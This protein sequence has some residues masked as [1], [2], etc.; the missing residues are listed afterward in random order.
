MPSPRSHSQKRTKC[1]AEKPVC[2]VCNRLNQPCVYLRRGQ[3]SAHYDDKVTKQSPSNAE[4]PL[5]SLEY[6]IEIY[7]QKLYFQPLPLFDIAILRSKFQLFPRYL[8]WVF[9][10]LTLKFSNHYFYDTKEPQ[11]I[12]FYTTSCRNI[13]MEQASDGVKKLEILQSLCLLA[14]CE[15]QEG[16][17]TR[18][19]M[20]IG[21][22]A[23]LQSVY[24]LEAQANSSNDN[25]W[26]KSLS[27]RCY[28]SILTLEKA[29][30]V[31]FVLLEQSLYPPECPQ[32]PPRPHPLPPSVGRRRRYPDLFDSN[33]VSSDDDGINSCCLQTIS[34]WGDILSYFEGI[35]LGKAENP[36]LSSSTHN[37]LTMKVYELETKMSYKHLFR[38]VSFQDRHPSDL[39]NY[40]EY[41]TPWLL[42]QIASHGAQAALNNPFIHLVAL[43]G[44]KGLSQ[45]RSFLQ[46]T[47]DQSLYHSGWV[48]RLLQTCEDL[49]FTISDPLLGHII[50]ATATIPWLFQFAR[51][52]SVSQRAREN[53]SKCQ[54]ALSN[55]SKY[56]PHIAVK[57]QIL[58]NLQSIIDREGP[59]I[60]GSTIQFPPEMMWQVLI[61]QYNPVTA[62]SQDADETIMASLTPNAALKITTQ[63][64]QPVADEISD[65][66]SAT[67]VPYNI[68]R[69]PRDE[70][71]DLDLDNTL[72]E[73]MF[74]NYSWLPF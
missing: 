49:S 53:L 35:R 70:Y 19:N 65:Q 6:F 31:N 27:S 33:E 10:A 23:R 12:E 13:V 16:K 29:F 17:H 7:H 22:A 44:A 41:W 20:T 71:N 4:P 25:S 39:S 74:S 43:R 55:I 9:L 42:M 3:R 15:I 40:R 67:D 66:P 54:L 1:P 5:E 8:R 38:N 64:V 21:L 18:A 37:Q 30:S 24:M 28:W 50:A 46:Q 26:D 52:P 51:D 72:S 62:L 56:W 48:A 32:S 69:F 57:R 63:I 60:D 73:S 11:A 58:A 45:P 14:L 2:S 61:L 34:T 68:S 47:V 59:N 36:W